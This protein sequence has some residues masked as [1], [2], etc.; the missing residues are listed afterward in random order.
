MKNFTTVTS[1][2]L[3]VLIQFFFS[4]SSLAQPNSNVT[5]LDSLL[6]FA[7]TRKVVNASVYVSQGNRTIYKK[8]VGL[9]SPEIGV[10]LDENS[11]IPIGNLTEQ[12][13][14]MLIFQLYEKGK[15]NLNDSIA[16]YFSH[17]EAN[18][19][20]KITIQSLLNHTSGIPSFTKKDTNRLSFNQLMNKINR[21]PLEDIPGN[22]FIHSNTN[23]YLLGKII[24][25]IT[26]TSYIH[27]LDQYIF[28]PLKMMNTGV[29]IGSSTK[30]E[31]GYKQSI[32]G[33]VEDKVNLN[34]V[35]FAFNSMYSSTK[36]LHLWNNAIVNNSLITQKNKIRY[37]AQNIGGYSNGW[38]IEGK[39]ET[40]NKV[41][42]GIGVI[43]SYNTILYH[44]ETDNITTI[45][46]D[47]QNNTTTKELTLSINAIISG[48]QAWIPLEPLSNLLY[49]SFQKDSLSHQLNL[50]NQYFHE[51]KDAYI[52]KEEKLSALAYELMESNFDEDALQLFELNNRFFPRSWQTYYALGDIHNKLGNKEKAQEYYTD[53]QLYDRSGK[54][55]KHMLKKLD[56]FD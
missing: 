54:E 13:T 40:F 14:A 29:V 3:I 19:Y 27:A 25:N 46:L 6:N 44:D 39:K 50:I 28:T 26:K 12:F 48:K 38:I 30:I 56:Q 23:Y 7:Y 1:L 51:F 37:L 21:S 43:Q 20:N 24:E 49:Q 15:L 4:F 42:F 41:R 8:G 33:V 52:V 2:P 17:F 9:K 32:K 31:K 16:Q 53:A 45:I 10:F 5:N 36:D 18:K 22:R 35:Y 34:E 55:K 47:N 11:R